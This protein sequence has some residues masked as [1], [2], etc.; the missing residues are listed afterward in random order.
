MNNR[1]KLA[2]NKEKDHRWSKNEDE[3]AKSKSGPL[4]VH[5]M[6]SQLQNIKLTG[7]RTMNDE[8]QMKNNRRTNDEWCRNRSRMRFESVSALF[9]LI[10]S[11]FWT[12]G[13]QGPFTSAFSHLFIAKQGVWAEGSS[14]KQTDNLILKQLARPSELVTSS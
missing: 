4:R 11:S 12:S 5:R 7:R 14:P 9:S 6:N 13:L 1:S 10:S 2:L 8:E 3:D